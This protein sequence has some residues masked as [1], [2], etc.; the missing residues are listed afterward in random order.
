M[1]GELWAV[2][3]CAAVLYA[4]AFVTGWV[5]SARRARERVLREVIA[6]PALMR[7]LAARVE[8]ARFAAAEADATR[9]VGGLAP[10]EPRD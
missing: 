1:G 8:D 9:R 6:D 5:L 10:R 3:G 2:A 7:R 4:V